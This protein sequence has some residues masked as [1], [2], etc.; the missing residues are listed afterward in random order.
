MLAAAAPDVMIRADVA[1]GAAF[2]LV[3]MGV[4]HGGTGTLAAACA[5]RTPM[6]IV[7]FFLDQPLHAARMQDLIGAP[8]VPARDYRGDSAIQ[9]LRHAFAQ[10][11]SMKARLGMLMAHDHDG[12]EQ[13]SRSVLSM[14][15]QSAAQSR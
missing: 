10:R 12:A 5:H 3:G 1:P 2:P 14:V 9:A 13:A 4:H 7:P 15:R 11:E 6:M 8:Q